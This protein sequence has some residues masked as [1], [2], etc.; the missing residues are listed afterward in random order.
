MK[1]CDIEPRTTG[2][3]EMS[4]CH[5]LKMYNPYICETLC[6]RPLIFRT[7]IFVRSKGLS[8]KYLRFTSPYLY[9]IGIR[10]FEFVAETQFLWLSELEPLRSL[11]GL[12]RQFT[13]AKATD[14]CETW[15]WYYSYLVICCT[16]QN[17]EKS[18]LRDILNF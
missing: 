5:K 11:F 7:K 3:K 13:I 6:R 1:N 12:Y 2:V 9:D 10:K 17:W 4:F 8:L 14:L 15:K 18:N 16:L